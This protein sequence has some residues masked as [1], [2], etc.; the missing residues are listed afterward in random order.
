MVTGVD[1]ILYSN[2]P[3]E[4]QM[5]RF[6]SAFKVQWPEAIADQEVDEEKPDLHLCF[7]A[8]NQKVYDAFDDQGYVVD[9]E[10]LSCFLILSDTITDMENYHLL[11]DKEGYVTAEAVVHFADGYRW[12]LVLPENL[13]EGNYSW[14]IYQLFYQ[15]LTNQTLKA[16]PK[17]VQHYIGREIRLK[18]AD[19]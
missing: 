16:L 17:P 3:R 13:E 4:E 18:E 11:F 12:T 5:E 15:V 6:L 2:M 19:E 8:P 14:R 7:I 10:G 9:E 1:Y